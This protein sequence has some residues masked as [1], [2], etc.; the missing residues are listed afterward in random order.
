MKILVVAPTPFF[1]D[2]GTHIRI[3]E[4]ALALEKLGHKITIATYHIGKDIDRY[5]DTEIDVRRIRRLLFWYKKLEAGPDWQKIILDLMLIRKVFYLARTQKPDII[6]GHLHEGVL[7][8]YIVQKILFWRKI[9]LLADFHGSL[10]GEMRSHGYLRFGIARIFKFVESLIDN[11]G[12]YAIISSWERMENFK[13]NPRGGRI[14]TVL[15]G[16]NPESLKLKVDRSEIQK[17]WEIPENSFVIGY[18]GGLVPNK[19]IDYFLESIPL[20][21]EKTKNLPLKKPFFLIGGFPPDFV[22][23]FIWKNNLEKFTRVV[24]PLDYFK[25]GEFLGVCD[26]AV[27]PKGTDTKQASGKMLNYMGAG[28]PV[29]CFDKVNN[30]RYLKEG[31]VFCPEINAQSIASGVAYLMENPQEVLRMGKIN[32]ENSQKFSWSASAEKINSIYIKIK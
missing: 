21:I 30:R 28:L 9:K 11:L 31:G 25:L 8:G 29:V 19:G 12:D 10:V 5:V 3:L 4:E 27:D 17:D 26:A 1:S 23:N 14:E 20:I 24:S 32:R 13:N 15:D 7:I 2:R 22:R 18:T 6:H 16:T